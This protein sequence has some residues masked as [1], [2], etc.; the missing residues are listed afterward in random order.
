MSKVYTL[1]PDSS[2]L[3]EFTLLLLQPLQNNWFLY[4]IVGVTF[5]VFLSYITGSV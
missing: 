2:F 5:L 1:L 4:I 3:T